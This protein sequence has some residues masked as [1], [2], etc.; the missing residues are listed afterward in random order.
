MEL[1]PYVARLRGDLMDV[2][3]GAGE[4]VRAAAERLTLALDPAVRMVLLEALTEAAAAISGDLDADAIDVRLVGRD[5]EFV[6]THLA[7]TLAAPAPPPPPAP[8]EPPEPDDGGLAR[9][10]VRLPETLKIR[11]EEQAAQSGQSL[12]A[13]IVDA[14]RA[15]VD[16]GP[17]LA[18]AV[19]KRAR[20]GTRVQGWVG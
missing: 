17:G 4:D 9:I 14:L 6:V 10:T 19:A 15:G 13:W 16:G 1:S 8:P 2:A 20:V 18:A 11:A 5:P 3:A 7:P 12:N